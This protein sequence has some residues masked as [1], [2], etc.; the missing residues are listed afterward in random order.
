MLDFVAFDVET[1]N[2]NRGSICSMGLVKV[3]NGKVEASA[4]WLTRPPQSINSFDGFNIG[5]HG[6]TPSMV[7][8]QP[9]FRQRL[10]QMLHFIEDFPI[11][12]HNAGFDMGALRNACD[13]DGI[14]WP[15]ITYGCSLVMSRRILNLVSY[16]LPLVCDDLGIVFDNHHNAEA[17]AKAVV[18][19]VS[20]FARRKDAK[21][22]AELAE[23]LNVH[24][25]KIDQ[26]QWH[27][28]VTN[29][30]QNR[31][32]DSLPKANE[33]A[34]QNHFLYRKEIVF[35]GSLS[36]RR[37]EAWEIAASLG[38]TPKDR[39]TSHTDIL[40][41]GDGFVGNDPSEFETNKAREAI[42][43][44][45]K[46]QEIEILNELDFMELIEDSRTFGTR[47]SSNFAIF[48]YSI[49]PESQSLEDIEELDSSPFG[50]R[51]MPVHTFKT[52]KD[53][54]VNPNADPKNPFFG[55]NIVFTGTLL[56]MHTED[57]WYNVGMLGATP[58]T[59]I[60]RK[61]NILIVSDWQY[62]DF[63]KGKNPSNAFKD[64]KA[65]REKGIPIHIMR[66]V[67]YMGILE[68]YVKLEQ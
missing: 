57:A 16:R 58:A 66:E 67:E 17:D 56:S 31:K 32:L 7:A 59:Y 43:L 3:R 35:T 33:N 22:L 49:S 51:L 23:S 11:V 64:A 2:S 4:H 63:E 42:R 13:A 12:S 25:G 53:V 21:S 52:V 38:A 19:I 47:G 39:M 41:I 50:S 30:S 18:D 10:D 26:S 6:I 29:R 8:D 14:D 5:I 27:G 54:Y 61:T 45:S 9:T 28:C 46:G 34:D 44:R 1:A 15:T 55:Q 60:T 36:V 62:E 24:L 40:V 20:E 48:S 65:L 37:E 68:A